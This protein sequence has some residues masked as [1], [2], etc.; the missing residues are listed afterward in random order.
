MAE[1]NAQGMLIHASFCTNLQLHTTIAMCK[2]R[3]EIHQSFAF[4]RNNLEIIL[5]ELCRKTTRLITSR[6]LVSFI[7]LE[8]FRQGSCTYNCLCP[9]DLDFL[10]I[11]RFGKTVHAKDVVSTSFILPMLNSD[12]PASR[13]QE[14]QNPLNPFLLY[15]FSCRNFLKSMPPVKILQ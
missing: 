9:P 1:V 3:K 4:C 13:T 8:S 2:G 7:V 14:L 5:L 15:S 12:Q 11:I 10:P 6:G